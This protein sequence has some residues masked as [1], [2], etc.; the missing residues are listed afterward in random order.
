MSMTLLF[1]CVD[2]KDNFL[3]HK[4]NPLMNNNNG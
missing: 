2:K 1:R 4:N 3:K